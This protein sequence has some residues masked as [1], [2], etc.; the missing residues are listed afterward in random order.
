MAFLFFFI[1]KDVTEQGTFFNAYNSF[2][3]G[4]QQ[5]IS[6]KYLFGW[7]G[8]LKARLAAEELQ[9]LIWRKNFKYSVKITILAL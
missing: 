9:L 3:A 2:R 8:S 1:R 6:V 7:T 5:D 4:T